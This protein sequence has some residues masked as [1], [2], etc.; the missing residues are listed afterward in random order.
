MALNLSATFTLMPLENI[1]EGHC[2]PRIDPA[3]PEH[4]AKSL[5]QHGTL[6]PLLARQSEKGPAIL[7]DGNRRLA[8]AR[9]EKW[10]SLPVQLLPPETAWL[11]CWEMA[12]ELNGTDRSL[13]EKA[14]ALQ[15]F[16]D[17]WQRDGREDDAEET[18]RTQALPRLGMKALARNRE[19]LGLLL[20]M[21]EGVQQAFH[22]GLLPEKALTVLPF[23]SGEDQLRLARAVEEWRLSVGMT[24][25]FLPLCLEII[26]RENISLEKLFSEIETAKNAEGRPQREGIMAALDKRRYPLR[27]RIQQEFEEVW[28]EIKEPNLTVTPP[29]EF[30]GGPFQ[31]QMEAHN[32][33]DLADQLNNLQTSLKENRELWQRLFAPALSP[34]EDRLS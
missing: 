19:K 10:E 7:I 32:P 27:Y 15:G 14:L 31:F 20:E 5:R 9:R 2:L 23:F 22:G 34:D 30:E 6:Q 18:A 16:L 17:C 8:F 4:L 12:V 25:R 11:E 26:K 29:P 28:D 33:E 13:L 21:P 24:H 1:Q 3:C